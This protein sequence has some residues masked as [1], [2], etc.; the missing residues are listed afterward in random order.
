[1]QQ[2]E[3]TFEQID[4]EIKQLNLKDFEEGGKHHFT[5]TAVTASPGNVLQSICSIYK[6]IRGILDA[7][8]NFP[9]L[10]GTWKAAIKTFI[11]LM[12]NLC[13]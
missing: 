1:M 3:L 8:A 7:I 2:K 12:D 9:L 5:A 11:S 4:A 10:P 6:R 13:P